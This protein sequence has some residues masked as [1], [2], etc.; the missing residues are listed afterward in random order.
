MKDTRRRAWQRKGGER[1]EIR[2]LR[3]ETAIDGRAGP[4]RAVQ[5]IAA[6]QRKR[7]RRTLLSNSARTSGTRLLALHEAGHVWACA[8]ARARGRAGPEHR[9]AETARVRGP[10]IRARRRPR[11]RA[12]A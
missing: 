5:A 11:R 10:G 8:D 12:L 4:V 3:E 7:R 6:A 1:P 2:G 9:R